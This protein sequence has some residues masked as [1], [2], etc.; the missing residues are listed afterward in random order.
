MS[1]L[2]PGLFSPPLVYRSIS[3]WQQLALSGS[4]RPGDQLYDP[5]RGIW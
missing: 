2:W 3:E 4:L 5:V 1:G